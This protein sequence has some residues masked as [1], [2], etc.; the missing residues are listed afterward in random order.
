MRDLPDEG[1][2]FRESDDERAISNLVLRAADQL[3][4]TGDPGMQATVRFSVD[5]QWFR[6]TLQMIDESEA[7][8]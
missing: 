4:M 5:G 1:T 3:A 8:R 6:C 7:S 2:E